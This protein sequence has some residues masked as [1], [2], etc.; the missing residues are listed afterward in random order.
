MHFCKMAVAIIGMAL[1]VPC[2]AQNAPGGAP[3]GATGGHN[4]TD[5]QLK[6]DK[7]LAQVDA[8]KD[9]KI[10]KAEWKALDLPDGVFTRMDTDKDDFL[11]LKEI[12]AN[13]YPGSLDTNKDGILTLE[14]LKAF[15]AQMKNMKAPGG[16]PGAGG[17][18][19]PDS[20]Q[21]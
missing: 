18:G 2:L 11:T 17:P 7:F 19:G 20:P 21:K 1:A 13:W 10:S 8:N 14:K 4:P 3:G 16:A 5:V 15:D 6:G 12:E 9:G